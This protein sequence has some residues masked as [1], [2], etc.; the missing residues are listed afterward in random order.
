MKMPSLSHWVLTNSNWRLRCAPANTKMIPRSAPSSSSTPCGQRRSVAR[1]A[2]DHAVQ[3]DVHAA[4]LVHGVAR[5]GPPGVGTHRALEP[6]GVV[7]EDEVVVAPG[8]GTELGVVAVRCE[9]ERS[10][11]LP[12]P[13][14]LRAEEVLLVAARRPVAQVAPVGRHLRVQLAEDDVGA[15]ATQHLRRRH[16]RQLAGLVGVAQDDLAGLER[17]LP[18]TRR[19]PAASLD[20]GLADAVLEAERGPSGGELVAVLTPDHL[21]S[22]QLGVCLPCLLGGR[23]EPSGVRRESR[24]GHVHVGAPERLLPVLGTALTHVSQQRRRAPPSLHGTPAR[25]CPATSAGLPAPR[26]RGR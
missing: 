12:A 4:V 15:V 7:G 21:H 17:W 9:G 5:V 23:L 22:R 25:S 11:A 8:I 16:R 14:H 10:A 18:G 26:D 3:P 13:D 20:R 2:P 6:A 1:S 24:D 19:G